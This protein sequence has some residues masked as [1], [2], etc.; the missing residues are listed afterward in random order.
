MSNNK[1]TVR[2][3]TLLFRSIPSP[4]MSVFVVSVVVMNL[5]ANK[6]VSL[7][8]DWLALDCGIVVSWIAFLSM[9][10]ITKH[11]GPKAATEA[12]LF[13]SA[14][15]LLICAIFFISSKV[16]GVWGESFVDGSED[17]INHALDATV[18][19]TWYVLLG[20]TIA[21]IVSAF[22]NNFVNFAVGKMMKTDGFAA[23]ACRTYIS[24]AVGQFTDNITFALIVSHFFFGWSL[25]Q[26]VT[27]AA[28]GMV[29]ELLCEV[30]FSHLGYTVCKKWKN[31]GVGKEY[32]D[33]ITE[34]KQCSRS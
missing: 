27:C 30:I 20:S 26:C 16:P 14:V 7:P 34:K 21:F 1:S 31:A 17:V 29:V 8:F 18:G 5:L 4:I 15:N 25:L 2:E 23:Y 22:V 10:I 24:T 12:S 32:F 6:S 3:L 11:F 28:T 33:Y 13:A 9:D 19:G